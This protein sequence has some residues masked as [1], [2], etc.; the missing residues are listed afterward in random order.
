MVENC[1]K[2][3][4]PVWVVSTTG[5][6]LFGLP[7]LEVVLVLSLDGS[8]PTSHA[9]PGGNLCLPTMKT[10]RMLVHLPRTWG[11]NMAS[12]SE[13]ILTD[14]YQMGRTCIEAGRFENDSL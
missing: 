8:S 6:S 5:G 14:M 9:S 12:H 11:D 10:G 3:G 1:I 4:P 13:C 7:A 2:W